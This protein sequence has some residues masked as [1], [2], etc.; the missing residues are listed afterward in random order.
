MSKSIIILLKLLIIWTIWIV[1]TSLTFEYV[2][3]RENDL[4]FQFFSISFLLFL[5]VGALYKTVNLFNFLTKNKNN[6]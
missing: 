1:L 5:T 6:D 3:N 4:M 2:I